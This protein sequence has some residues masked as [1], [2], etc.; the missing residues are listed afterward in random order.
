MQSNRG[1]NTNPELVL[2]R[3]LRESGFPG[4]R[5]HWKQARGRPDIA[6]PGRRVAIFVNGCFWHQ[7]PRCR[8]P[9]PKANAD[10]WAHKLAANVARDAARCSELEAAGWTVVTV[11]EC[12]LRDVH[13]PA[14]ERVL[15]ALRR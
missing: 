1:K 13:G 9:M 11:W 8:L 7:C 6:Y 4:Y 14:L 3:L 10:F 2:R 15:S 12:D 5:L